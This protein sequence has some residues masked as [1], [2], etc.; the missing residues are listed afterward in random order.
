MENNH[1]RSK[2]LLSFVALCGSVNL[3]LGVFI[4]RTHDHTPVPGRYERG[5][6]GS[7]A[8]KMCC[9]VSGIE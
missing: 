5:G 9:L 2:D 4:C 6:M 3:I 8:R 1:S 7:K